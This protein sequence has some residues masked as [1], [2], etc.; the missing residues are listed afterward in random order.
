[1]YMCREIP[2]KAWS[3]IGQ[4]HWTSNNKMKCFYF[5]IFLLFLFQ[6][7]GR[8]VRASFFFFYFP[9]FAHV[10]TIVLLLR[11]I[12]DAPIIGMMLDHDK[13]CRLIIRTGVATRDV[14]SSKI[15]EWTKTKGPRT[16]LDHALPTLEN[17]GNTPLTILMYYI[18]LGIQTTSRR[19]LVLAKYYQNYYYHTLHH[20]GSDIYWNSNHGYRKR[21]SYQIS[22]Q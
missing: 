8:K 13:A 17:V 14:T 12:M 5:L 9:F 2:W 16:I 11:P 19:T 6:A 21:L 15:L 1:M 18:S 7:L 20:G 10:T 4:W 3:V 22:H